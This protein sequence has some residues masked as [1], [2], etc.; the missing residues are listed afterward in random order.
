MQ[1]SLSKADTNLSMDKILQMDIN[2]GHMLLYSGASVH[3]KFYCAVGRP[4]MVS[5]T[6]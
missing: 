4:H 5:F 3:E 6:A 1:Q 2:F